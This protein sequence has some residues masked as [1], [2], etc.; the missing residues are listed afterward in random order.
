MLETEPNDRNA[1]TEAGAAGQSGALAETTPAPSGES[2]GGGRQPLRR[3]R[4]AVSKAAA[5][6]GDSGDSPADSGTAPAASAPAGQSA[7]S[8]SSAPPAQPAGSAPA[9]GPAENAAGSGASGAG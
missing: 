9:S 4:R 5:G 7:T 2:A 6:S 1:P 3:A 8:A